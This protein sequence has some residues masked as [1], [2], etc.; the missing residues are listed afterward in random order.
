MLTGRPPFVAESATDLLVQLQT[1][2]PDRPSSLNRRLNLELEAICQKCLE[3]EPAKRY[4]SAASLADDLDRW[5]A[6]RPI[7]ARPVGKAERAWRWCRRNRAIASLAAAIILLAMTA[8]AGLVTGVLRISQEQAATKVALQLAQDQRETALRNAAEAKARRARA[9]Q[10]LRTANNVM[11][12]VAMQVH[13]R[14]VP[15]LPEVAQSR[16]SI[17]ALAANGLRGQIDETSTDPAVR[18]ESGIAY[19]HLANL[20]FIQGDLVKTRWAFQQAIDLFEGLAAAFPLDPAYFIELGNCHGILGLQLRVS[21]CLEEAGEQLGQADRAYRKAYELAPNHTD[22]IMFLRWFLSICP[23][24][25]FRDPDRALELARVRLEDTTFRVDSNDAMELG[26]ALYRTGDLE[27]AIEAL[28][29]S[30]ASGG[31]KSH[32]S[33]F[34]AMAYQRQGNRTKALDSY[35]KA[36]RWMA[37]NRPRDW[38]LL[39]FRAEA[40]E[41][42]GIDGAQLPVGKSQLR[43]E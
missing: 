29:R 26:I 13:T 35:G 38:E 25:R 43:D 17:V 24:P 40:E 31:G 3:K 20:H 2:D 32:E 19:I 23:D 41:L 22:S 34:L 1:R 27:G 6:D 8:A 37:T 9:I 11:Q 4:P 18:H 15:D 5:L 21:G 10:N 28:E 33:F 12:A 30:M 42:L 14:D 36:V 7:H 16:K 39:N